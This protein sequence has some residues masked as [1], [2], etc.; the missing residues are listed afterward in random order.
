MKKQAT[1]QKP[2]VLDKPVKPFEF[3]L[4]LTPT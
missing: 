1:R 3:K 4:K 2:L